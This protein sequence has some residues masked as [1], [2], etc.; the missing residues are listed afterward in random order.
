MKGDRECHKY[1]W[2]EDKYEWQ[3]ECWLQWVL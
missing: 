3:E 2:Q 1:E